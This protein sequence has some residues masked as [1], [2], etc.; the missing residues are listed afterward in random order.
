MHYAGLSKDIEL[1]P[2]LPA[3]NCKD[4]IHQEGKNQ[5]ISLLLKCSIQVGGQ[6]LILKQHAVIFL[7]RIFFRQTF[8]MNPKLFWTH[9]F[10]N[11]RYLFT[12]IYF[13]TICLLLKDYSNK[14]N[15]FMAQQ[16]L[17][18]GFLILD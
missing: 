8:F 4:K 17:V 2:P 9:T 14:Y 3:P 15:S 7:T 10:F 18:T 12:H 11:A 16:K 13:D 5:N 6:I 1:V